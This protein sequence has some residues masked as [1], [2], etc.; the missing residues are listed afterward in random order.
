VSWGAIIIGYR[1]LNLPFGL[2]TGLSFLVYYS[3]G[4]VL[5][6]KKKIGI[7]SLAAI[8]WI[9][10]EKNKYLSTPFVLKE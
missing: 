6:E 5:N 3:F 9:F 10:Y 8:I 7:F 4:F 2:L 1:Y